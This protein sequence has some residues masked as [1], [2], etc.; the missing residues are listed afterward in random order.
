MIYKKL[1]NLI[2]PNFLYNKRADTILKLHFIW[3][4]QFKFLT[5]AF[6]LGFAA[7]KRKRGTVGLYQYRAGFHPYEIKQF[8]QIG[9]AS[10][11]PLVCVIS[12]YCISTTSKVSIQL[13]LEIQS[14]SIT[15]FNS[16]SNII[17][18]FQLLLLWQNKPQTVSD[19]IL[20]HTT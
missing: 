15:Y 18:E 12:Q 16:V 13:H 1:T 5:R 10:K 2:F 20:F 9:T 8:H 4:L 14:N 6:D 11:L 3:S 19:L 7:V 17:A